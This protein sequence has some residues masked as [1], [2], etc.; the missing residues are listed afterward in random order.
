MRREVDKSNRQQIIQELRHQLRYAQT[1][2]R[3][4]IRRELNFW[5]NYH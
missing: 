5:I 3:D 4:G 2:E 1:Q